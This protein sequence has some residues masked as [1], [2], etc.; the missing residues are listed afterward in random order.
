[1]KDLN[2]LSNELRNLEQEKQYIKNQMFY[3]SKMSNNKKYNIGILE[4]IKSKIELIKLKNQLNKIREEI[5]EKN[6]ELLSLEL[7]REK[8]IR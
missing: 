8:R 7:E 6:E 4:K 5:Q 1:M 3:I 2:T